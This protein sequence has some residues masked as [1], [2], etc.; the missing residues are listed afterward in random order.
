M[1]LLFLLRHHQ[2]TGDDR[3]PGD[4]PAHRR[5]DGPRRHLRPARRR[6][7]PVLGGRA[8]GPCRTSRRCSTTTRCC[9]GSTPSCG[10]SPA[11]RWPGGW[12]TRR[13]RSSLRDLHRRARASLR[14]G[15]RHRRASRGSPTPGPRPSS[16][17]RSATGRRA[18]PP[19]C[20]RS[21]RPA[22]SSTARSVLQLPGHRRR[23]PERRALAGRTRAAAGGPRQ[24]PAA[25][26]RRQGGGGLE[27]P[28]RHRAWSSTAMLTFGAEAVGRGAAV[29]VADGP[30]RRRTWSTAG[31][32]GSRGT[33][34]SASRPAC[35]RTTAAW[36]RRSARCTS[37]PA[38][39]AGW[40]W[41]A[42]LLDVALAHFAYRRRRLL[43]HRRR[44]RAA[45]QP[46]RPT[47]PTTPRR[48]ACRRSPRRWSAYAA[49]TGET[50]YR[51]AAEAALGDGRR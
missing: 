36:P 34:W 48:P 49:L 37:S 22:R 3:A 42:Q 19:T 9:C 24:P 43:R 30:G 20:S 44:R 13:R 4:R 16:S 51:E 39:G 47:R 14:A 2:R 35:W 8:R 7:R 25:G 46:A 6:L 38:T 32:G 15:R 50:R 28:G 26:P 29:E 31:C 41:P 23:R 33:A 10:G 5:A 45:G 21:P 1:N 40:S 12:P 11:T 27:R 17:R 18:G